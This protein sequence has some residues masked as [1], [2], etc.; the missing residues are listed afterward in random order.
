MLQERELF[1]D[2]ARPKPESEESSETEVVETEVV[3]EE[4]D[5]EKEAQE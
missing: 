1:I 2:F 3:N 4:A 5:E